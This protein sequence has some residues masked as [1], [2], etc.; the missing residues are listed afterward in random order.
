M[1]FLH[2]KDFFNIIAG[3]IIPI[4]FLELFRKDKFITIIRYQALQRDEIWDRC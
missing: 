1:F 2:V 3:I 4:S